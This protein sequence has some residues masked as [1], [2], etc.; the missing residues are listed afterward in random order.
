[1]TTIDERLEYDALVQK[2]NANPEA[3]CMYAAKKMPTPAS[4][5]AV[6]LADKLK[7]WRIQASTIHN[8][9]EAFAK[10]DAE[11]LRGQ[12]A[13]INQLATAIAKVMLDEIQREKDYSEGRLPEYSLPWWF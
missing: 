6:A 9:D 12:Q 8:L 2:A 5:L 7:P 1:M 11:A 3:D 4:R 13:T 10:R